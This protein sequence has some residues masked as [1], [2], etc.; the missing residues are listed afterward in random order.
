MYP[1][2]DS[3]YYDG[4]H[5]QGVGSLIG[6]LDGA[7]Y[8]IIS[9]EMTDNQVRFK[10]SRFE[11]L[12]GWCALQNAYENGQSLNG[13]NCAPGADLETGVFAH[14]ETDTCTLTVHGVER[15]LSFAHCRYCTLM[16][17]SPCACDSCHCTARIGE[18]MSFELTFNGNQAIGP[19]RDNTGT[20]NLRLKR[21]VP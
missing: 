8:S 6:W 16:G 18:L 2:L 15:V 4:M 17:D 19:Y 3:S 5:L 7:N 1:P 10:V 13:Y 12:K 21:S 11:H 14:L 20:R 9:G